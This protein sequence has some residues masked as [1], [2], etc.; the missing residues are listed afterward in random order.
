MG[1]SEGVAMAGW[2][3]P[4]PGSPSRPPMY[5]PGPENMDPMGVALQHTQTVRTEAMCRLTP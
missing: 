1:L 5:Q 2:V 4:S 3:G